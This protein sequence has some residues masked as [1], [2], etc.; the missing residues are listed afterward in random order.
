M[1]FTNIFVFVYISES[2]KISKS[3]LLHDSKK[4]EGKANGLIERERIL[5]SREKDLISKETKLK[6]AQNKVF[7]ENQRISRENQLLSLSSSV[8]VPLELWIELMKAS[9]EST[10][11][12]S[13]SVGEIMKV[14][15]KVNDFVDLLG[16]PKDCSF[17]DKR[18][19]GKLLLLQATLLK[20]VAD[21]HEER[22]WE[23]A[24]LML[25][26]NQHFPMRRRAMERREDSNIFTVD[27]NSLD[28][29]QL[30]DRNVSGVKHGATGPFDDSGLK[31]GPTGPPGAQ[32]E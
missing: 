10:S 14:I 5:D 30:L 32:C 19:L 9:R 8:K 6:D 12:E 15:S 4:L 25:E 16:S 31:A 11:R 3:N 20:D 1:D 26:G 17:S 27:V 28:A 7:V 18:T 13:T 22:E 29:L 2:L 24:Q 21:M 23:L